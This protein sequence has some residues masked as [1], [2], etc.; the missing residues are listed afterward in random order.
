MDVTLD[1]SISLKSGDVK[2]ILADNRNYT[3]K[4]STG[5]YGLRGLAC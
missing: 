1:L 5:I 3:F 4:I 2:K